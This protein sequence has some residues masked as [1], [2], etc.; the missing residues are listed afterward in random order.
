MFWNA[1]N[2]VASTVSMVA[3]VLTAVY[4][5]A[6]LKGLEKDRFL[7]VTN[8]LFT[9]WQSSEF[10]RAQLWLLHALKETTWPEFVATHRGDAGEVAF[11]RVGAFYDR[12]GT[13]VRLNLVNDEQILATVGGHAI[14]VWQKVEPLVREAR[15][16]ENSTLFVDFERML[17]SCHECYVPA[18]GREGRVNPFSLTQPHATI[19]PE[20]LAGPLRRGD[21][22]T[23][24]DVRQPSQVQ[25]DPR[26]VPGAL[27]IPPDDLEARLGEVPPGRDIA[28][29]CA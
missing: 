2:A 15:A 16:I 6:Q 3:F 25:A 14:A 10:M 18:L 22:P 19:R 17:P 4:V 7:T 8:D 29:Y 11:H 21:P 28:V 26:A 13:L 27:L 9:V 5:R 1:L 12:V 24:L 23:V 20:A